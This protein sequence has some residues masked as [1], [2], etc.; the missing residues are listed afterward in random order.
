VVGT[1]QECIA[2]LQKY[3]DAG[4]TH[5]L[6]AFGAGALDTATVRESMTLFAQTVMPA[7][8]AVP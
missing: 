8:P 7:F 2:R 4:V 1:P 5:I 3:R 6:C